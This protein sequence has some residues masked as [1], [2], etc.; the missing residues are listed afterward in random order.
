MT[1]T[2]TGAMDAANRLVGDLFGKAADL[3]ERVRSAGWEKA[4]DEAFLEAANELKPDF[5]QC[6]RGSSRVYKT[7]CWN[8]CKGSCKNHAHDVGVEMSAAQASKTV[9]EIRTSAQAAEEANAAIA[10][11]ESWKG[12]LRAACPASD[13]SLAKDVKYYPGCGAKIQGERFCAKCGNKLLPG[14]KFCPECGN[15]VA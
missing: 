5:A 12:S 10:K 14:A 1:G 9:E 15:I 3:S 8:T 13:A 2:V 4:H 7:S 6:P 11:P